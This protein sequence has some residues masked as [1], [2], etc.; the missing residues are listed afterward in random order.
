MNVSCKNCGH[1][2][3]CGSTIYGNINHNTTFNNAEGQGTYE[4]CRSC[5]CKH[6]MKE[7]T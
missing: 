3:H 7:E 4:I 2:S 1:G 6:C 5:R